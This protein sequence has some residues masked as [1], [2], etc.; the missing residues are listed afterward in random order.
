MT[1]A[2]RLEGIVP[3]R[4]SA[5][6]FVPAFRQRV[7]AGLLMAHP[8][9]RSNYHV[10]EEGAGMLRV[11]AADYR[12]A[13][14]VGL[15]D[16]ELRFRS[17]DSVQFRV[18]Y[19]R[20][21]AYGIGLSGVMGLIGLVLLLTLDVR[22]YIAGHASAGLPG[23]SVDQNLG[24]AWAFVLFWGFAWPWLLIALHKRGVRRLVERLVREVD[25]QAAS[26]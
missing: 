17:K 18:Q 15:N 7:A 12:T 23:L 10:V 13:I 16:L 6:Q 21:A 26:R 5:A 25:G 24:V 3:V 8:H 2:P 19:W 9:P 20:W 14:S 11:R 1:L 4:S 22:G